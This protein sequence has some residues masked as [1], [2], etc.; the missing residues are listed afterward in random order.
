MIFIVYISVFPIDC[1]AQTTRQNHSKDPQLFTKSYKNQKSLHL[2]DNIIISQIVVILVLES[3]A[4]NYTLCVLK[5]SLPMA[6]INIVNGVQCYS[7]GVLS[8]KFC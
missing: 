4:M 1:I 2:L 7:I 3:S 5:K 8:H 6:F